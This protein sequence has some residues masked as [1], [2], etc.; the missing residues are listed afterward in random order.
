MAKNILVFG[1]SNIGDIC[2]DLVVVSALRVH[3][4]EAKISFLCSSRV[5]NIVKAC[6]D[7]DQVFTFDRKAKGLWGRLSLM[8]SLM[9]CRFDLAVV[10]KSTLMYKFL[11]IPSAWSVRKY[12]GSAFSKSKKHILDIYLEF[13]R[14]YGLENHK[15]VFN[16]EFNSQEKEFRDMFLKRQNVSVQDRIIGVLPLAAWS[17]KSWPVDRWLELIIKLKE[18]Y[19]IKVI[20]F[21]KNSNDLLY[22]EVFGKLSSL[23]IIADSTTLRQ[24]MVLIKRCNIFIGPDSGFLH[25]ASCMGVET[26]GLYGP[27]PQDYIFPYFHRHNM[28]SGR[29]KLDCMPCYPGLKNCVCQNRQEFG[30]CMQNIQVADVLFVIKDKLKL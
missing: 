1:H 26:I 5:E 13:M 17:L 24:A 10:L 30:D 15:P 27:T 29:A 7:L 20:A 9:R 21:G 28:V 16:I 12:L 4:P 3:F 23:A 2:Y 22:Y 11:N 19:G 18:N 25:L 6:K 8:F 14:F